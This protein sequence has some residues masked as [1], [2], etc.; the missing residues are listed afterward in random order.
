MIDYPRS[1]PTKILNHQ[2]NWPAIP[3]H[4]DDRW[5]LLIG[6]H[7]I[8]HILLNIISGLAISGPVRVLD[9]GNMLDGFERMMQ[10]KGA[11]FE[12]D[13]IFLSRAGSCCQLLKLLE[14]MQ[15]IST[16]FVVVDLLAKFYEETTN[17][18]EKR[19]IMQRCL[20]NLDR[21]QKYAGG[22]VNVSSPRPKNKNSEVL[23]R[24][25]ENATSHAYRL[26][27]IKPGPRQMQ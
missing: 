24:M 9:G 10:V 5:I 6:S 19:L 27:V 1:G 15:S 18:G 12:L 3:T 8:K 22:I 23:F 21:L 2:I 14:E 4:Q 11:S 25:V 26:E 13:R 7:S 17:M 16:P 20:E